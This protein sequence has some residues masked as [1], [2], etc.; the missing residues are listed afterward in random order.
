M[1]RVFF[2]PE[3]GG[4]PQVYLTRTINFGEMAAGCYA[5]AA[6][7]MTVR[8][9]GSRSLEEVRAM[10]ITDMVRGADVQAKPDAWSRSWC[11]YL[12]AA[13]CSCRRLL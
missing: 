5:I 13:C 12:M 9:F 8:V 11:L 2:K 10:H 7:K 4:Q 6:L 3:L 1:K